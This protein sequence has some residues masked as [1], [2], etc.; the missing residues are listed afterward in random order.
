METLT[1][2]I[3]ILNLN[4]SFFGYLVFF[5]VL[6]FFVSK[7]LTGPYYLVFLKRQKETEG[8][9]EKALL[10][11]KENEELKKNYDKRFVEWNRRFQNEIKK[12]QL[13]A[14]RKGG[15]QIEAAK[16]KA[17]VMTQNSKK[18]LKEQK[19]Q[20]EAALREQTPELADLLKQKLE[21]A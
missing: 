14:L 9:I 5:T 1:S 21:G 4:Q 8:L 6:I 13:E 16:K 17:L 11:Q 7:Y 2:F 18:K 12:K 19:S 10:L 3:Q 20:A 15:L